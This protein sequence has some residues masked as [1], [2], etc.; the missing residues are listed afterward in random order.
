MK[1]LILGAGYGVRLY[2]LTKNQ[3]K[4]LIHVGGRPVIEWSLEQIL[5]LRSVDEVIIVVNNRFYENYE[6]WH[7]E[8]TLTRA[9]QKNRIRLC[10][11]GT[12]SADDRL[13]A[14]GDIQFA[15][16]KFSIRD[17]LLVVAGDNLFQFSLA[18]FVRFS[19]KYGASIVLK[20]MKEIDKELISQYSVV[21]LNG[22]NRIT[23]FEEKPPS[24]KSSLIAICLYLFPQN[25]LGLIKKY[26]VSG[27]NPD[28]PGY[29]IQW[30][31][32]QI[33]VYGYTL[34]GSWFDIGDIDSYNVANDYYLIRGRR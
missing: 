13:G 3:P 22:D 28:A 8:Y 26:L 21:T 4:P 12:N 15:I 17:D 27:F 29:Y 2:P 9:G 1:A 16:D 18:D 20:N 11:D 34:K 33:S 24:P 19:K 5:S 32:K 25:D 23:D 30:L 14:I 10:N 6:R 31:Y 7:Y